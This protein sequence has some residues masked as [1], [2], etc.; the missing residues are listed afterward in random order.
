MV[1]ND[2][3]AVFAFGAAD[4]R[5][6]DL[7]P[8]AGFL[9]R[10]P[11]RCDERRIRAVGDEHADLASF[12]RL[13]RFLDQAERRRRLHVDRRTRRLDVFRLPLHAESVFDARAEVRIDVLEM[14][15]HPLPDVRSRHLA[16]LEREGIDDVPLL[17]LGHRTVEHPRLAVVIGERLRSLAHTL[18]RIER[19][20]TTRTRDRDL[21]ADRRARCCSA[22]TR[23]APSECPCACT[24]SRWKFA[25]GHFGRLIGS[26]W[27]FAPP[28]RMSCV[29]V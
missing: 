13:R 14:P 25:I 18:A 22:R 2:Q 3:L 12:E 6:D 7:H 23:P 20:H 17:G 1:G 9:N 21:R 10:G 8:R 5:R 26:S 27:K 29:S 11:Q 15:E 28:S 16:Q 24:P 4:L 19:A